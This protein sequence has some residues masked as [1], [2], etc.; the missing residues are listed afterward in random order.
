MPIFASMETRIKEVAKAKGM[1]L[2]TLAKRLD[3]SYQ[4]LNARMV[5]N[6]SLKVL[7]EIADVLK[8]SI[9]EIIASDQYTHHC[10]DENGEWRGVVRN[11]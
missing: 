6:P 1:D 7:K 3:I 4:A 9:F 10:Y 5:G 2:K 8:V 11:P